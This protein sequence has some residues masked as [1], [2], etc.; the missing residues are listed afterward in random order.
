MA[1]R[2]ATGRAIAII[3]GLVLALVAAF[4]LWRYVSAAD[5]RAQEGAELVDVFV[6]TGGIPEGMTAQTAV[7]NRLIELDQLP[8]DNRPD[9]AITTYDEISGM[10]ALAPIQDG[11]ILQTGQ[12]GDPTIADADFKLEE[13]QVAI[14]LQAGIPEGVS[15]FLDQGDQVGIIAHIGAPLATSEVVLGPDGA[16]VIATAQ[17]EVDVVTTSKYVTSAEILAIGQRIISTDDE[18]NQAEGVETGG[19]VLVTLSVTP[20]DAERLV[21]ANNE[22]IMHFTLLPE[23]EELGDTPGATFDNLFNP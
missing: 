2:A 19:Q 23:G 10:A 9:T 11:A 21:F 14:S 3:V 17:P 22:G 16:P 15:G 5:Q 7:S 6:A 1:S 20:T 8:S 18:G 4:L 12:F 13:G